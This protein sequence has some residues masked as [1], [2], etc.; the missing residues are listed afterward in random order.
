MGL[1]LITPPIAEPVSL[2]EAKVHLRVDSDEEDALIEGYIRA[3][4]RY[5]EKGLDISL[6]ERTW[7]MTLDAFTRAIELPRGPV[8]SVTSVEYI[9]PLGVTV[10]F[11]DYTA[12][13]ISPS[14][15]I[16]LNKDATIPTTLDAVNVVSV[17]YVSGFDVLPN[18]Y[19]DLKHAILLLVGHWYSVRE[20]VS[21]KVMAEVPLSVDA[22]IYPYRTILV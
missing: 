2:A 10:A 5:V 18:V 11:T 12:D 13:L 17:T 8:Q 9:D 19:E 7:K 20:S 16:V 14:Q 3:A 21:D 4:T 6:M 22:L 1:E 15:W